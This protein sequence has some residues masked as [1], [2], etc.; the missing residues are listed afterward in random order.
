MKAALEPNNERARRNASCRSDYFLNMASN[1]G[2]KIVDVEVMPAFRLNS[3][4]K[5]NLSSEYH[6]IFQAK[7]EVKVFNRTDSVDNVVFTES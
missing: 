1:S 4:Q 3:N 7:K 6:K 2:I 5:D